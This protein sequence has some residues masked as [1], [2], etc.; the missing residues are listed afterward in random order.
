MLLDQ[1]TLNWIPL[2]NRL[3]HIELVSNTQEDLGSRIK[4]GSTNKE[5]DFTLNWVLT[6]NRLFHIELG[7]NNK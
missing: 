6:T 3:L 7:S 1:F 2:T 5:A 4:L